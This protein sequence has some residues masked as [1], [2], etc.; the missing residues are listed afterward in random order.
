MKNLIKSFLML[1]VML[2]TSTMAWAETV[3]VRYKDADGTTKYVDATVLNNTMNDLAAGWYVVVNSFVDYNDDL[4]TNGDGDVNIILCDGATLTAKNITPK[5]DSDKIKIYGQRQGTGTADISG[6]ITGNYSL[7]IY[8]GTINA[9]E[10]DGYQG[11]VTINGGTVNAGSISPYGSVYLYGGNVTVTGEINARDGN[12]VFGGGTVKA[13]SYSASGGYVCISKGLTY[14][15]G[16]G[17]SYT[18]T[19]E[20][21]YGFLNLTVDEIAAIAGKTMRTN[22]Y[23]SGTCGDPNVNEGKNVTWLLNLNTKTLTISGTEAMADFSSAD[24]QPWKNYRTDI[25]RVTIGADITSISDYAFSGCSNLK[26]VYELNGDTPTSL[27][28]NAFDG[29]HED[30]AIYVPDAAVITYKEYDNWSAYANKIKGPFVSVSMPNKDPQYFMTLAEAVETAFEYYD[31]EH[32]DVVPTLTLYDDIVLSDND[33]YNMDN[34]YAPEIEDS[35]IIGNGIN[36]MAL[37]LDLNGHKITSSSIYYVLKVN[38]KMTITDN[39][40]GGGGA[41][42]NTNAWSSSDSPAIKIGSIGDLTISGGSISGNIGI[43]NR[44]GGTL[45]VTGGSISGTSQGYGNGIMNIGVVNQ[46]NEV[47]AISTVTITGGSI[48]GNYYGIANYYG[49]KLT[50][51]GGE[52]ISTGNHAIDNLNGGL[53]TIGSGATVKYPG[54]SGINNSRDSKMTLTGIPTFVYTGEGNG[55]DI[56]LG[57][58]VITFADNFTYTKPSQPIML[59]GVDHG[60]IFTSGYGANCVYPEGHAKAG[61]TVDPNEVFI[62]GNN[63]KGEYAELDATSGEVRFNTPFNVIF[64]IND[65]DITTYCG[66]LK[67]AIDKVA[68]YTANAKEA[69]AELTS[70]IIQPQKD[71]QISDADLTHSTV[72]F[73]DDENAIVATLD[74]NGH[75]ITGTAYEYLITVAEKS[76]LTVAGDG[77]IAGD[78]YYWYGLIDNNG[79]LNITGGTFVNYITNNGTMTVSGGTFTAYGGCVSIN[80]YDGSLTVSGGTFNVYD[81]GCAI[82]NKSLSGTPVLTLSALPTFVHAEGATNCTDIDL[83]ENTVI[84]FDKA[85]TESPIAPIVV[86]MKNAAPYVF[87]NGYGMYVKD[88]DGEVADPGM[89]FVVNVENTLLGIHTTSTASEAALYV[90]ETVTFP[91]GM[92]TYYSD[93]GLKLYD[94]NENLKFYT[95]TNAVDDVAEVT[96][97]KGKTFGKNTPL[98]VSNES[99]AAIDAV[100]VEAFDDDED[101]AYAASCADDLGEKSVFSGFKGTAVAIDEIGFNNYKTYFGFTGHDFVKIRKDGPVAAHRCWIEMGGSSTFA[102]RLNLDWGEN[103]NSIHNAQF[104]MHNDEWYDLQGRKLEGMPNTPG[105]YI[106]EGKKVFVK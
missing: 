19:E 77:A 44:S 4:Y 56:Y 7:T 97:I 48:S 84:T 39:A 78:M 98:I 10:L 53:L 62:D 46:Q 36:E 55:Y 41:I 81:G 12:V 95:V 43:D 14:Y 42:E 72:E 60:T 16:T 18:G 103:T 6:S 85:I 64:T 94:E 5:G 106:N 65:R 50:V 59:L 92:T 28:T 93:K 75:T 63:D 45:T 83:D 1:A 27:G 96:E 24:D 61:Q 67:S 104:I 89:L 86:K 91:V 49:G 8:G 68:T 71:Y 25:K 29:C 58:E 26:T 35:I 69:N 22:D 11:G 87:T 13:G 51:T 90:L 54:G 47:T 101:G 20:H 100:M 21:Y 82:V 33:D 3:N 31:P 105:V 30:L 37:M 17:A 34:H 76:T 99:N 74:L 88:D 38:C 70:A 15:D 102:K 32:P 9:S 2:L 73:G 52:I 23:R 40:A 66:T 57:D 80:N 79:T